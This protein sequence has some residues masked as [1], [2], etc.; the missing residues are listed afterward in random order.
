MESESK[1]EKEGRRTRADVLDPGT[2]AT[3]YISGRGDCVGESK[4]EGERG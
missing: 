2:V 3:R 4:G 1:D